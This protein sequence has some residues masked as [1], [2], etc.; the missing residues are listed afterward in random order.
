MS[1]LASIMLKKGWR[2]T[3]S[4]KEA[5]DITRGLEAQG[6]HVFYGHDQDNVEGSI[7]LLV[8]TEAIS[9]DNSEIQKAG[10]CATPIQTY[11]QALGE[12]ANEHRLVLVT[13][14]HGKTTTTGMIT[15]IALE[16]NLDPTVVIGGK[17]K[18][19]NNSN[20]R[21]GESDLWIVE[22]CEYRRSFLNF[23]PDVLVITNVDV[24]H[25]DYYKDEDDYLQAFVE[26][27]K[28]VKENGTVV[29]NA[30]D[31]RAKQAMD[32]AMKERPDLQISSADNKEITGLNLAV[33]GEHN[34]ANAQVALV[35][36]EALG[37]SSEQVVSALNKFGGTWRR[38]EYL[39]QIGST[40][41]YDDYAHHPIEIKATLQALRE[42]FPREKICCVFQPH[43]F[44]R[45][46]HFFDEFAHSFTLADAVIVPNIYKVRDKE[47]D[48]ETLHD[49]DLVKAIAQNHS[50]VL[51]GGGLEH[52]REL[53]LNNAAQWD[54]IV[55]MGA[56]DIAALRDIV[57]G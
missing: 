40:K 26:L 37:L 47:E 3:G 25:L 29:F 13:G 21:V 35:A 4:D 56:G 18:E 15:K 33:P 49:E 45:T 36:G 51:A 39:G 7:D 6:I 14:T 24:D 16:N 54:V 23:K 43:Q 41:V 19:L 10:Y 30:A 52:T 27:I 32:E 50:N 11:A 53:I 8:H 31:K 12:I 5:S 9:T 44:N 20:F 1:A 48:L 34:R 57:H 42:I 22:G 46:K 28:Q 55:L 17:M 2:I 38:L